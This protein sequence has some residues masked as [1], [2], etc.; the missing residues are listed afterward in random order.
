MIIVIA[1][2]Y[3][4]V[5]EVADIIVAIGCSHIEVESGALGGI[6][7]IEPEEI[8][9][10]QILIVHQHFI[11]VLDFG[12]RIVP[13]V[14]HRSDVIILLTEIIEPPVTL[15]ALPFMA[16]GVVVGQPEGEHALGKH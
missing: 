6:L 15:I 11:E 2:S 12:L 8:D 13:Y 5:A 16:H 14:G 1:Q 10:R 9:D 7:I 3:A 4:V